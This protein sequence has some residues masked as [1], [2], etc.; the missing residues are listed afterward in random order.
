MDSLENKKLALIR[1][2]Q[3][4]E[5]YSDEDHPLLQTDIAQHLEREYGIVI[6]RKAIG[7]NLSLLKDLNNEKGFEI[8]SGHKGSYLAERTFTNAE[9][10]VLID[11]VL[12]SRYISKKYSKD[13]IDKLCTLSNKYFLSH[14]KHI[15]AVVDM[16]KTDNA[17]LFYNIELID[18]AIEKRRQIRFQYNR[19]GA[20]KK[21]H[22]THIHHLS[23]YQLIIQNQRYYLMGHNPYFEGISFFRLDHITNMSILKDK[24]EPLSKIPGYERGID[25]KSFSAAH[26]YLFSDKPEWVELVTSEDM[27]DQ[28]IDWFGTGININPIGNGQLKIRLLVSPSAMK[29]WA[30]QYGGDVT[31]TSPQSLVDQIKEQIKKTAALYEI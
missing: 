21:L 25:Y 6:E 29:Y 30:L 19:Y 3:I 20:D 31:V 22:K 14:V 1:I 7:R 24:L 15:T 5:K 10:R 26:P 28:V 18:E 12:S 16:D 4:L 13:L 17:Q 2:L 8:E 23:P 9:L 27:V 11:G